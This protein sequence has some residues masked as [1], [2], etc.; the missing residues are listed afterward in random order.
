MSFAAIIAVGFLLGM[1]HALDPD[2]VIAVTT[3]VLQLCTRRCW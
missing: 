1:R 3:V 2:H